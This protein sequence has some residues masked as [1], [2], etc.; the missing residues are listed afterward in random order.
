M[1]KT[2][3]WVGELRPSQMLYTYGIGAIVDLPNISAIVLGLE[4]WQQPFPP[5]VGEPRLLA[6]VQRMLGEQVE[7]LRSMPVRSDDQPPTH[8]GVPA[9]PPGVPVRAFP[10]WMVCPQCR[11]LAPVDSHLFDLKADLYR[12][13]RTRY[14]HT[15]CPKGQSTVLPVR[16]LAAC[17]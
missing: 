1:A 11:L 14:V 17:P 16:F 2:V 10:R 6:T 5:E 12:P 9:L 15:N 13:E 3:H 7:A 8:G 4:D